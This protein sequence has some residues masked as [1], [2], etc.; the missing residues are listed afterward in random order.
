MTCNVTTG[1]LPT[2]TLPFP[3]PEV[4]GSSSATLGCPA[5]DTE[6]SCQSPHLELPQAATSVH[7]VLTGDIKSPPPNLLHCAVW[8]CSPVLR[9]AEG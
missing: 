8:W 5:R 9:G 3:V 1:S 6:I 7:S 4:V 2:F